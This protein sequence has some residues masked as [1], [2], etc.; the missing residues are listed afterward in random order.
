MTRYRRL[1]AQ[2]TVTDVAASEAWYT[3]LLEREPDARPMPGL[4][5]YHLDDRFG[6]QV[7]EEPDRA[8]RASI[9]FEIDDVDAL[10]ARVDEAGFAHDGIQDGGGGRLLSIADPDGTRLVFFQP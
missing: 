3:R 1:L 8:G 2:A 5:E 6:L 4:I 9:L 10:V 7:W